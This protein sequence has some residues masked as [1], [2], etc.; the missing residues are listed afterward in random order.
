MAEM[1]PPLRPIRA[2]LVPLL[3]TVLLGTLVGGCT[4][5]ADD[6]SDASD[7]DATAVTATAPEEPE[8][9]SATDGTDGTDGTDARKSRPAQP[10]AACAPYVA[11][12]EAITAAASTSDD[13][14]E[15]AA[16]IGPVLKEFA[17]VVPTLKRPGGI[18]AE[19]W[20]GVVALAAEIGK[21]PDPPTDAQVEAVEGRL[22]DA[23]KAAVKE[24]FGWF[25]A[26]CT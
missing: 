5:D 8:S 26:T 13:P 11:M 16:E 17:E 10:P 20:R 19:T 12:V 22:S 18:S 15:V 25:Q 23:E 2:G 4:S 1:R 9:E 14:D 6:G 3:V 24:A 21:L 7:A